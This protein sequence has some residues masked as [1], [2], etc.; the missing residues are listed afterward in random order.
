MPC[1]YR[2]KGN[3]PLPQENLENYCYPEKYFLGKPI[4]IHIQSLIN[5]ILDN[6]RLITT[7]KGK[8]KLPLFCGNGE[9]VI[10]IYG[11]QN[12]TPNL[13]IKFV[14]DP[15]SNNINKI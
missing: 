14:Y 13:T 12:T 15:T 9:R 4:N 6:N 5:I 3:L 11:Q 10:A 1:F 7:K 8:G 2:G